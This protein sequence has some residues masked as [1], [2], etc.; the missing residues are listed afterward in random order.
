MVVVAAAQGM[1]SRDSFKGDDNGSHHHNTYII[2]TLSLIIRESD[3]ASASF[4][5]Y[6]VSQLVHLHHIYNNYYDVR[7]MPPMGSILRVCVQ[8][9]VSVRS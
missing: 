1:P 7:I 8:L 6:S 5:F 9:K 4:T 2:I 3:S